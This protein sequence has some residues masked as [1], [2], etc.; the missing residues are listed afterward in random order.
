MYFLFPAHREGDPGHPEGDGTHDG[1]PGV[2]EGVQQ[3]IQVGVGRYL[4]QGSMK[5]TLGI[6]IRFLCH[7]F[8][9]SFLLNVFCLS[10]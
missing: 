3:G 4:G 10:L 7:G 5:T 1:F 2:E 8:W 6:A 9:V